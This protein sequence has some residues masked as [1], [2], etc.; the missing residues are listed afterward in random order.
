MSA[1]S[2]RP[3][4]PDAISPSVAAPGG[5]PPS[6]PSPVLPSRRSDPGSRS[7]PALLAAAVLVVAVIVLVLVFG[8]ARPPEL[9]TVE[10]VPAP[11][12]EASIVWSQWDDGDTCIHTVDPQGARS[13]IGCGYEGQELVAWN[14]EGIVVLVWGPPREAAEIID[15]DTGEIVGRTD[16]GDP[17][18]WLE[19]DGGAVRSRHRDGTLTVT[20]RDSGVV[21][22]QVE[23]PENYGVNDGVLSP[24]GRWVVLVDRSER[25]L[26]VPADGSS[27]PRVWAEVEDSWVRPVWEGS[28][29]PD[30]DE[31]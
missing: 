8:I 4:S 31:R 21:L 24:D 1:A 9:A 28:A 17:E 20:L 26:L 2:N 19:P 29:V 15:P 27:Q 22:W 13:E 10:E 7:L 6:P 30:A 23:A 11:S 12:P 5:T 16:V 25:L 18:E 3:S 14:E